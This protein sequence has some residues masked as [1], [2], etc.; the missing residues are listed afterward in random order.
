VL[1]SA[2]HQASSTASEPERP[3]EKGLQLAS[4]LVWFW[5][6]RNHCI[7][8]A[9]WLDRLIHEQHGQCSQQPLEHPARV[10]RGRALYALGI[11]ISYASGAINNFPPLLIAQ[12]QAFLQE[13]QAI[14]HDLGEAYLRDWTILRYLRAETEQ[15][16]LECRELFQTLKEPF[17]IAECDKEL[18]FPVKHDHELTNFYLN[19]NLTL[20][21]ELGDLEGLAWALKVAAVLQYGNH[22]QYCDL[23][24]RCLDCYEKLGNRWM[25]ARNRSLLVRYLIDLG[26]YQEAARQ[27]GLMQVSLGEFHD[28]TLLLHYLRYRG[29]LAWA[30]GEYQEAVDCGIE[31]LALVKQM[32]ITNQA[33]FFFSRYI[34]VRAA[35]SQRDVCQARNNLKSLFTKEMLILEGWSWREFFIFASIHALCLLAAIEGKL[36]Q[37]AR[38]IGAQDALLEQDGHMMMHRL[39]PRGRAEFEQAYKVILAGLNDDTFTS[40]FQAGRVMTTEQLIQLA[41]VLCGSDPPNHSRCEA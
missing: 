5:S 28:Q 21:K 31:G 32:T 20:R 37:A 19:E 8:G 4:S 13:S 17:W 35:L 40:A 38:L 3:I 29:Y 2:A 12:M 26:D 39:T 22:E 23:M 1:L 7:E 6:L 41:Q 18:V 30:N 15:E 34:L 24:Q 16:V 9:E 14:F 36:E 33:P 25:A 10:V 27:I 11:I